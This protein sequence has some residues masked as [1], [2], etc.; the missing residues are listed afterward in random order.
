MLSMH[1][2]L[3]ARTGFVFLWFWFLQLS[4]F[5]FNV[6]LGRFLFVCLFVSSLFFP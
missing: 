6:A 4:R 5:G 1:N 2:C 3:F